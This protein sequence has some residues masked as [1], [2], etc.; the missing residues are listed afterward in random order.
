MSQP[1]ATHLQ[2]LVFLQHGSEGRDGLRVHTVPAE[3]KV[4]HLGQQQGS[5]RGE[6]RDAQPAGVQGHL[7][8]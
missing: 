4:G 6:G 5:S 3:V 8:Q 2:G 1:G 7:R